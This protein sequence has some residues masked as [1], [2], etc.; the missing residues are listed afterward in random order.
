MKDTGLRWDNAMKRWTWTDIFRSLIVWNSVELLSWHCDNPGILGELVNIVPF[1]DQLLDCMLSVL[2]DCILEDVK[3]G[4]LYRYP[5]RWKQQTLPLFVSWC[6]VTLT[7]W[8][9]SKSLSDTGQGQTEDRI[10]PALLKWRVQG[11]QWCTGSQAGFSWKNNVQDTFSET[12][13]LL[14]ILITTS[15]T[16]AESERCFSALKRIKTFFRNN[17]AQDRLNAP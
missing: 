14:K 15:M 16:T 9:K 3:N 13:S 1:K 11:L 2:Q 10:V 17:I 5:S 7:A 4:R 12:I 6:Y 8:I